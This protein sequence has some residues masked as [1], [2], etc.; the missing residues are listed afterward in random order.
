MEVGLM[1]SLQVEE[2]CF[3]RTETP[4]FTTFISQQDIPGATKF[5]RVFRYNGSNW[6]KV[7]QDVF[8]ASRNSH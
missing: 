7:G 2:L 3:Q 8:A 1:L 6:E 5:V 4:F